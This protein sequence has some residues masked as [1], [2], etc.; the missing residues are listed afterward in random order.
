MEDLGR[1]IDS[2]QE[3][4]R[5]MPKAM[6]AMEPALNVMIYKMQDQF[7]YMSAD[8]ESNLRALKLIVLK[9]LPSS[10]DEATHPYH[11]RLAAIT[12]RCDHARTRASP[13]TS[14]RDR[15]HH[16]APKNKSRK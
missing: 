16:H 12:K 14:K 10:T 4:L 11:F 15:P 2:S 8:I 5:T 13:E 1:D 3:R 6:R 9:R 7:N